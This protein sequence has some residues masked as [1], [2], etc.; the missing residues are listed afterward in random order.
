MQSALAALSAK[1]ASKLAES[2]VSAAFIKLSKGC[3]L[4]YF[5]GP[6]TTVRLISPF[7]ISCFHSRNLTL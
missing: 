3:C 4:D 1:S 6:L 5:I 2:T 7:L